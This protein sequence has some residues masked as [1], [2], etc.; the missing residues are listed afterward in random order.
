LGFSGGRPS[1]PELLDWLASELIAR[2]WSLKELHRLIVNSATYQQ[3]SRS[4]ADGIAV[5]ADNR[6]LWRFSPR[7][8]EAECVRDAM[9]VSAGQLN[10]QSGG[11]SFQDFRPYLYKSTQYYDPLDPVGPE[12]NRRSIYRFWARGGRSPLLDT[13]DCPDPS[14][15]APRRAST[16]TPLQALALF[17]NSFTL[18][19]ADHFAE[20]LV[21]ERSE[22]AGQVSRAFEIAYGRP[23]SEAE[24]SE[25]LA[26][27]R[28]H[29][30]APFCRV[31]FNSNGFLYVD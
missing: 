6:L 8:L 30:L 14:V 10:R 17:N 4:R 7:R 21:R 11:P 3:A 19:M 31:M 25:S 23:P 26:F 24:H 28:Q 12:Y 18:R 2:K 1:H 27:V 29:G 20:R 16:T 22:V 15:T 13:F 5:D 9:L